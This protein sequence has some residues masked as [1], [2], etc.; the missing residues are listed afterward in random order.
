MPEH[1]Y[2]A[3]VLVVIP[4]KEVEQ[5]IQQCSRRFYAPVGFTK[6]R[7]SDSKTTFFHW[8]LDGFELSI[9]TSQ[10]QG[11]SVKILFYDLQGFGDNF[12]NT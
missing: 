3:F 5:L 1:V 9:V 8:F 10:L 7:K 11:C 2:T 4:R 6:H 12:A